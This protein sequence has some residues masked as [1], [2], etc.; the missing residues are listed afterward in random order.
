MSNRYAAVQWNRHKVVYDICVIIG[1]IGFLAAFLIASGLVRSGERAISPEIM[2]IRALGTCAIVLLHV[3]L[4][5]GPL[6]RISP[7]FLPLLYNRR[8]LGVMTFIVGLAHALLAT[9]WYGAFGVVNPLEAFLTGNVRA[10]SLH[11][12]FPSSGSACSR[13]RSYSSWPRR[14]MTSGSRTSHRELG[15]GF[16]YW[17]TSPGRP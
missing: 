4:C 7:R 13:S 12:S 14:A 9:V 17:Y 15:S 1:I 8:H 11:S 6:C 10:D 16:I 5:I 3:V 2:M